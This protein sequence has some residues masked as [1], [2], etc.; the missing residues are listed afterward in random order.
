ML[1][2]RLAS[3]ALL[4]PPVLLAVWSG[5]WPFVALV[6]LVAVWCTLEYSRL[7]EQAGR[8]PAWPVGLIGAACLAA[9]PAVPGTHLGAL[10]LAVALLGPGVYLL[11]E[12]APV[13]P[14]ALQDWS[15]TTLGSLLIGWPL[16]QGV[17][18]RQSAE[19]AALLGLDAIAGQPVTRG[20]LLALVALTC[21]WASDSAAYA[22]GRLWGRRPFFA[23]ISPR[24]TLEGV[25]AALVAPTV[26]AAAWAPGLGWPL[27][28]ALVLGASAG[29]AAVAGDLLESALKRSVG[30]K[31]AG[32]LIPGH[33]GLLDRVDGLL[34]VL[35]AVALLTGEVWP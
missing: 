13:G 2:A 19:P 33:G 5:R 35:V 26:V 11:A 15:L 7:L 18:L 27:S 31:D 4:A 9:A 34:M 14:G 22:A 8:R 12:A 6:A 20:L 28:F 32:R 23:T 3:A 25:A 16:A 30:A 1:L 10:A 17:M 29:A 21:T 24:K